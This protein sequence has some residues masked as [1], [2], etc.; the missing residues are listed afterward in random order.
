MDLTKSTSDYESDFE[1]NSEEVQE[2]KKS[3]LKKDEPFP[4]KLIIQSKR[5]WIM[6]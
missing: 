6:N 2:S 3:E 1:N 5:N 4:K